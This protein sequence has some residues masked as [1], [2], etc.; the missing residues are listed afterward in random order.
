MIY[1]TLKK[2]SLLL[3][4]GLII[5]SCS[6]VGLLQSKK[7]VTGDYITELKPENS[8]GYYDMSIN[9]IQG[10][11]AFEGGFFT[12][13]TSADKFLSINYLNE[14]GESVFNHRFDVSSHGQDLSIE[15]ISENELY[16]YTTVGHYNEEGASSI[17]RYKAVLP[18]KT[19]DKRD[20]SKM[21]IKFDKEYDLELDN[22][23][24]TLCEEGTHFAMRSGNTIIVA[25]KDD[26]LNSDLS[27]AKRFDLDESQLK[28]ENGETLWFQGIAMKNDKV[29]CM[30]GNNSLNS[31]KQ[32]YVYNTDGEIIKKHV[33]EKNEFAKQLH[34]K[35]EPEGMTFVGD[36]L[37]YTIIIKGATGGNR[38]FLYKLNQ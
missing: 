29:Y 6:V 4:I 26:V 15:K 16:L 22:C 31:L 20:M 14:N 28:G 19:N 34:N 7:E 10:L 32:I 27:K 36:D 5:Q 12:T 9:V 21:V 25:T 2:I 18:V 3:L 8:F 37:Y 38:K 17:I 30:T 1:K 35:L 24:P 11:A 33:I 23:T 13:Q